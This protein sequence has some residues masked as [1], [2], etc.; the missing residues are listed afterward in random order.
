MPF[1]NEK[2][3]GEDQVR[4]KTKEILDKYVPLKSDA[5]TFPRYWVI[6]RERDIFL[7]FVTY[8]MGSGGQSGLGEA[9][10]EIIWVL[11]VKGQVFEVR[12][13]QGPLSSERSSESP[14]IISWQLISLKPKDS[15]EITY[16]EVILLL[17]EALQVY[18]KAGAVRQIP[19]TVVKFEF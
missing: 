5:T 4:Y 17:K 1:E 19:N 16:D 15:Q 9:T 11:S 3:T 2:L 18:G 6:D 12:L 8:V 14:Y 10:G 13:K 7:L